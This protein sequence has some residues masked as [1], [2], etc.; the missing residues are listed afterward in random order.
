M[1]ISTSWLARYVDAGLSPQHLDGLL[2]L[3]GL[4]V[5]GVDVKGASVPEGVVVGHVQ[6]AEKHPDA[7]RL[8]VCRVDVGREALLDIVCGAPNVA[9]GQKVCVATV[10]T[11]LRLSDP[12]SGQKVPVTMAERKIRGAMSQGMICA[13]DELGL[14]DDH[15][16]ILVLDEAA[17]VG[18]SVREWL[19][20]GGAVLDVNVT[21]N[22]PDATSHFGVARDVAALTGAALERPSVTVPTPGG[23]AAERIAVRIDAPEAC[24]RYTA[25]VVEDVAVGPSPAWLREAVESIGLRSISNV[26]DATNFVLHEIG[27]PLHAFDLDQIAGGQIVVRT[28]EPGERFTT[29]DGK[30]RALP[31]GAL[32]ICDAER[33]VALAGVMGGLNS[34]VT[35]ATTR[36]LIESAHFDPATTRRT[37]KALDLSTDASYRFERGVD[38][39]GTVWAA[40]R[41]AALLA[42]V[43]GGRV[44]PGM[45]DVVARPFEP[46]H[47]TLRL[48]RIQQVLGVEVP[49]AE[50]LRLLRAIGFVVE[51]ATDLVGLVREIQ[52]GAHVDRMGAEVDA[53][54]LTVPSWRP[55]VTR[56]ID[57]IEEVA[58][59]HGFD[60]LPEP[61]QI[62][63]PLAVPTAN[64]QVEGRA[65]LRHALVGM[66]LREVVATSLLA[67]DVAER[68][69]IEH[70]AYGRGAL[71]STHDPA[72]E[73]PLVLRPSLLPAALAIVGHNQRQRQPS[74][75][76]FEVGHVFRGPVEARQDAR[77][78]PCDEREHAVLLLAG[79]AQA[80][81][82]DAKARA[83]D[84]FDAKGHAEALLDALGLAATFVPASLEGG[85]VEDALTVQVEGE[86]VGLVGRLS[87]D[88]LAAL[89]ARGP[90][91]FA[92]LRA[93]VLYA[94]HAARGN[95]AWRPFSRHQ[96]SERDLAFVLPAGTRAGEVQATI[97]Q[98]AGPYLRGVR[99]FDRY[100]KVDGG[101]VSLAF[102][103]RFGKD[104]GT[105]RDA[106][107]D[108]ATQAVQQAVE[109][110]HGG[111]LRG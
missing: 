64:V 91:V 71:V 34:E 2:T 48:P 80:A 18:T 47:V 76:M 26:V 42:E 31:S 19:G 23:E 51:E 52:K 21:P 15:A 4:E 8:T 88:M 95:A 43:A 75:R 101:K 86:A 94:R 110:A 83:Y 10:G 25:L 72:R 69:Q 27:Q 38:P 29:L 109:A 39:L 45:V 20:A 54:R 100:D 93:D 50:V 68:F 33:A 9:A 12:K 24:S 98:A 46:T 56:E 103:L 78:L 66:G 97:E 77:A 87:E 99:L 63:M 102:A 106:D 22:R 37:A 3:A 85:P 90:V 49:R 30:D 104:D 79:E 96:Q 59:L 73:A 60:R 44:V 57:V 6:T 105:L 7:D 17:P 107:L 82:W 41:C 74:V 89:D 16:G 36:V 62:Q 61:R 40:A 55:D 58:R 65:R 28:A 35:A 13:E 70:P 53:L 84:V 1:Q 11:T 14:S 67:R 92:E 111:A 32:L 5:E 81:A 108:A